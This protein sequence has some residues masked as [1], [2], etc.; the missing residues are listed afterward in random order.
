[1]MLD[2]AIRAGSHR[3]AIAPLGNQAV[4]HPAQQQKKEVHETTPHVSKPA[5][6]TKL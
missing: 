3:Q 6:S 5:E 2:A 4:E 1:M